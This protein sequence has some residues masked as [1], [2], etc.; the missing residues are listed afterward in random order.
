M[1]N[2]WRSSNTKDTPSVFSVNFGAS[3]RLDFHKDKEVDNGNSAKD[4][5]ERKSRK[6]KKRKNM[7]PEE[8]KKKQKRKDNDFDN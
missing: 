2:F 5:R 4:E 7:D 3:Y 1:G 8:P 6:N